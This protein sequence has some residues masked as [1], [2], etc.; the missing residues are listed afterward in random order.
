[1]SESENGLS[2]LPAIRYV[3]NTMGVYAITDIFYLVRLQLMNF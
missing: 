2:N 1:M 3:Y